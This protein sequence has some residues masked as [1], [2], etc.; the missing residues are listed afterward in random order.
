MAKI[1][2]F[3]DL[4]IW[5][6]AREICKDVWNIIQNTSLQRD[7][8]LREQINGASGSIMDN[9]SEGFERDGNR[10]FINFLS[11][12]KA[13]CGETRSQLYRC[14]D[15]NHIDEETFKR[16]SEKAILN[17]RKIKSFMIYLKNSDKKGSKYD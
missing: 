3:E 8:K 17:S 2:R 12:A 11:I 6:L 9:I 13:S 5:Q 14:L 10:E 7:Y 1:E 4:E 15:R 16:I